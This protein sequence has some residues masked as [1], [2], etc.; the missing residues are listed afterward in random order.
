MTEGMKLAYMDH[1]LRIILQRLA[2]V[3][4]PKVKI[5]VLNNKTGKSYVVDVNKPSYSAQGLFKAEAMM[6]VTLTNLI[7]DNMGELYRGVKSLYDGNARGIVSIEML[8]DCG[9]TYQITADLDPKKGLTNVNYPKPFLE[10]M[11]LEGSMI[12]GN[13]FVVT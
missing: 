6:D 9:K 7:M 11:Y 8:L 12:I 3:N 10:Q 1:S 5:A 13:F 2:T 4:K